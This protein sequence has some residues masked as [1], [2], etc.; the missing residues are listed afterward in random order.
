MASPTVPFPLIPDQPD[1]EFRFTIKTAR[2][3][4]R[5][6][7]PW[8]GIAALNLRGNNVEVLVMV[9]HHALLWK[10]PKLAEDK[11][12]DMIQTFVDEGGNVVALT[13]TL[14]KALDESGVYGRPETPASE[15][16]SDAH[17]QKTEP[18]MVPV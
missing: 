10:Q 11:V 9:T 13:E 8:G 17:P 2:L 18:E 3:L 1:V 15:S 16:E 7:R 5:A 4:E 14:T 6:T 12:I